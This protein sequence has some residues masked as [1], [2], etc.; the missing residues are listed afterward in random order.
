ML[1][2][3][4]KTIVLVSVLVGLIVFQVANFVSLSP[5]TVVSSTKNDADTN[6]WRGTVDE[7]LKQSAQKDTDVFIK[8]DSIESH[9]RSICDD[10]T[11]VKI[12]AARNGAIY[13]S[14][15]SIITFLIGMLIQTLAKRNGKSGRS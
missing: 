14:A 4:R 8:L 15:S 13:G 11:Q 2:F 12:D 5:G 7:K 9:I 3:F 10:I 6:Y 1:N